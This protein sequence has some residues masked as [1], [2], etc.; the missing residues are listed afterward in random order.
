[1]GCV[2]CFGLA[3]GGL[4]L[5][6][7][8]E[9]LS[10][11]AHGPAGRR[12]RVRGLVAQMRARELP[13]ATV[14][15]V[16]AEVVRGHPRH[17]AVF[18]GL[19]REKVQ[20]HPV[21]ARTGVRGQLLGAVDASSELAVHAFVIAAADLLGGAVVATVDPDDLRRL[22]GGAPHITVADIS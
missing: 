7:D 12:D 6:L 22:A 9:A 15:A 18:A 16:L 8:S 14:A 11:V 20:V 10:A 5:L 19:R 3:A 2:R 21:D 13:V 17:A 4:M 1:M